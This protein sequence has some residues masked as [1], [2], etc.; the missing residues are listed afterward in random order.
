M[1]RITSV[2]MGAALVLPFSASDAATGPADVSRLA[3]AGPSL[4][5]RL[6]PELLKTRGNVDL[7][8][9]LTGVP[10]ALANGENARRAGGLMNR[11]QQMAHSQ[12]LRQSQDEVVAQVVALGGREIARV[13]IA[14]NAVVVRVDAGKIADIATI[15]GVYTVK[16]VNDYRINLG[17]TVPYVGAASAKQNGLDGNGV[18]V[19]VL[20]S[21]IDYTHRNLDGAGTIAAYQAVYGDGPTDTRN[22][23][24]DD[25]F[26]TA[27]VVGGYDFVGESWNG[28]P[29][30]P[31]LA[32]DPDPI[33]FGGH[34]THVADVIAGRSRDG[35]H[36]GI[37]PGAS[38]LAVKVC[39]AISSSCSG[40]A[41]LAGF[42]F[43]LDPNGDGAMDDAADVINLSLGAPYGQR[44]DSISA[45]AEN[46]ARAGVVVVAA[47]GNSSDKQYVLDSPAE[48]PDV[49]AVAQTQ[50]PDATAVPLVVSSP[51]SIARRYGNTAMIDWAPID[52]GARGEVVYV[53]RACVSAGDRIPPTVIDRIA[54]IDRGGCNVSEKVRAASDAG[55]I[56]VLIGLAAAGDALS[57]SNGGECPALPDGTCRPTLVIQQSLANSIRANIRSTVS[58]GLSEADAIPLVGSVARTSSRGPSF[59]RNQIKPDLAAPGASVSALAGTG[60]GE[61]AFGGTSGATPVVAGAAAILVQA[62]PDRAP[63][64][65]KSLL[66]NTA[67]T[68][69]FVNPMTQPGVLAP[70]SR[71][72]AGEARID[73]A[74][75]STTAAW[76]DAMRTGSLS[77]GY[78]NVSEP[79]TLVR[80]VRVQNYGRTSRSYSLSSEF[81]FANDATGAVQLSMPRDLFV[82][83]RG[84]Q[85]FDV[86]MKID[87]AR[88]PDWKLDGGRNGGTGALLEAVEFDGYI[89]LQD[90]SDEVHLPWHVLPHKSADLRAIDKTVTIDADRPGSLVLQNLARAQ[91]GYFEVFALTG[92]SPRI[93]RENLPGDGDDFAITDLAAVGVRLIDN[94]FLQFAVNTFGRRAHP[95]YPAEFDVF[96]D[97]NLDGKADYDVF[98]LESGGANT[99][100]QTAVAVQKMPATANTPARVLFFADADLDSGNIILTVPLAALQIAPTTKFRFDVVAF[101][102]YFTGDATDAIEG[103]EFTPALPRFTT[104]TATG[105]VGPLGRGVLQ[106][107]AVASGVEASPSQTGLLLLYRDAQVEA[108]AIPV[109]VR[110]N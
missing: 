98:T 82:P 45:A 67:E 35:R 28:T 101:D 50:V 7:V 2:V 22:T 20:D 92:T 15:P 54:L 4:T 70:I 6:D 21:G 94:A 51:A 62:Y 105:A 5:R 29:T 17:E 64:Q 90:A 36:I 99:T 37:A 55:A 23:T 91:V 61:E 26:P 18:K 30:S 38:L 19:A 86:I 95:A 110:A 63:W 31:P 72:G 93:P 60:A 76:D 88:L 59:D 56:G 11:A 57:F 34:G 74:L 14:Y 39:S 46:A 47:A 32:P 16:R 80:R 97:T 100:G 43:A 83:A 48:A 9:Q 71:I 53:G 96:I 49:I 79:A 41:L 13:R 25:L 1:R 106:I 3:I 65:I 52:A 77:F 108:E 27:K 44:E 66:M 33:D 58:V 40:I 85:T 8:V 42:D 24:L 78:L 109:K 75:A 87:P 102:N 89:R 10:L 12:S 73:R 104:R 84:S 81:R 69:V 107:G 103:M 68:T